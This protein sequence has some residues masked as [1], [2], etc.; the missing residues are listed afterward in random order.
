MEFFFF[1][2]REVRNHLIRSCMGGPETDCPCLTQL[3]ISIVDSLFVTAV[4]RKYCHAQRAKH[5][6]SMCFLPVVPTERRSRW[7][8]C[9]DVP[10]RFFLR[11][12]FDCIAH[13][14]HRV[15]L[16]ESVP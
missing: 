14:R 8:A 1:L 10:L 4:G 16:S 11:P 13:E 2:E 9:E 7:A 15:F 3:C 6:G 5:V 12:P